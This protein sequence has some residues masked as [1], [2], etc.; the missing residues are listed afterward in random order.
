MITVD[1]VW[2]EL[3]QADLD[4]ER[5]LDGIEGHRLGTEIHEHRLEVYRTALDEWWGA[6]RIAVHQAL[7]DGNPQ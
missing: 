7:E 2:A 3:H 6:F 5:A 4:V 1:T